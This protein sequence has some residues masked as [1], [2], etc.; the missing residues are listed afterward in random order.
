MKAR[1]ATQ[2][3]PK[4]IGSYETELSELVEVL[5]AKK[6][7]RLIDVGCAEGYYAVGFA[8][9]CPD[10][11]VIAVDPLKEAGR[12]LQGLSV[13]NGVQGRIG[14]RRIISARALAKLAGPSVLIVMD[15]EGAELGLLKPK[16][17]SKSEILVEVH[18]FVLPGMTEE[19]VNRFSATHTCSV[20]SQKGKAESASLQ[21]PGWFG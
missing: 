11:N 9:R 14:F 3:W 15:C 17:L 18:D 4:L 5:I 2:K 13:A 1:S 6:F 8:L 7:K 19:L 12:R 21:L 16:A 10:M 20:I